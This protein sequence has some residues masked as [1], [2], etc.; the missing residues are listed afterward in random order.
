[1]LL[2]MNINHHLLVYLWLASSTAPY[3]EEKSAKQ[4]LVVANQWFVFPRK[5]KQANFLFFSFFFLSSRQP[6]PFAAGAT[7]AAALHARVP[8][9]EQIF[10]RKS[11]RLAAFIFLSPSRSRSGLLCVNDDESRV[12]ARFVK[13]Q[14]N[15]NN[16]LA[17]VQSTTIPD[18]ER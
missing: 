10:T 7:A 1:M 6:T 18:S 5:A 13:Q 17:K 2:L 4:K 14:Q 3:K 8:I 16:R 15:S 9:I 12:Q 11:Q